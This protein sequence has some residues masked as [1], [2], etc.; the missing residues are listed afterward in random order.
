MPLARDALRSDTVC[1]KNFKQI[2]RHNSVL[3][4]VIRNDLLP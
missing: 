2:F 1:I 4:V 3:D